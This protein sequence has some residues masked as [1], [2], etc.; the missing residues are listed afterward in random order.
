MHSIRFNVNKSV[1]MFFRCSRNKT[2]DIINVVLSGKIIDC[3]HKTEY[4]SD[5]LG[6]DKKTSIDVSRQT[7]KFSAQANICIYFLGL[8]YY[9][10]YRQMFEMK[11]YYSHIT[12]IE[13]MD[14]C[15]FLYTI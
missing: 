6:S 1:C 15:Y 11:K 3:V 12:E 5:H 7:S 4:L 10:V 8:C 14:N 9:C 13:C 2:C